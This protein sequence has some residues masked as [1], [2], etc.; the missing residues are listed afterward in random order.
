VSECLPA[1]IQPVSA[2][3][4]FRAVVRLDARKHPEALKAIDR[5]I[6]RREAMERKA[7]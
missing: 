4:L 3:T 2:R 7:A 5:E 1:R 6:Q